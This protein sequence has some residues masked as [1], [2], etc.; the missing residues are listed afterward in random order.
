MFSRF[1]FPQSFHSLARHQLVVACGKDLPQN[2]FGQRKAMWKMLQDKRDVSTKSKKFVLFEQETAK[3]VFLVCNVCPWW[4]ARKIWTVLQPN[5]WIPQGWIIGTWPQLVETWCAC[6]KKKGLFGWSGSAHWQLTPFQIFS[7]R[8]KRHEKRPNSRA[9]P[10]QY[11]R[12]AG[13]HSPHRLLFFETKISRKHNEPFG[14]NRFWGFWPTIEESYPSRKLSLALLC[15]KIVAAG[16]FDIQCISSSPWSL[17]VYLFGSSLTAR[18]SSGTVH[19]A[20]AWRSREACTGIDP[21]IA[22]HGSCSPLGINSKGFFMVPIY[23][24]FLFLCFIVLPWLSHS[25]PPSHLFQA[26]WQAS[27]DWVFRCD[28]TD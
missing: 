16:I 20:M 11:R 25:Q 5:V 1:V 10:P 24:M 27:S 21:Q 15:L 28:P 6:H 2:P 23:T 22:R 4:P 8:G 12:A 26:L 19:L 17:W 7:L 14:N 13:A 18:G 9:P 3:W